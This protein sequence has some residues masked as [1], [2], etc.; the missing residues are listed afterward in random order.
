MVAT[1]DLSKNRDDSTHNKDKIE[2]IEHHIPPIKDGHY[3]ITLE[4]TVTG[5]GISEDN[6]FS[7]ATY[8]FSIL[9]PR[10]TLPPDDIHAVFPPAG[11]LGEHSN[12]FPHIVFNRS[13]LPWERNV[14][15]ETQAPWLALL[16]FDEQEAPKSSEQASDSPNKLSIITYKQL[17]ASVQDGI[18]VPSL[19][20]KNTNKKDLDHDDDK[21]TVIDVQW[22]TL[23]PILPSLEELKWLAHVR[24]TTVTDKKGKVIEEER[25]VIFGDRLPKAGIQSAVHLVSLENFYANQEDT[26]KNDDL[27]RLV[28]LK[29][30]RFAC[31]SHKHTFKKLLTGID[32]STLRL[33]THQ[34]TDIEAYYKLGAVPAPHA[35]RQGNQS[36][37]WY[38]GPLVPG[39]ITQ[40]TEI[41]LPVKAA[42]DL[43]QYNPDIGM[44]DVSYS[45]AWELGRLI[46]LQN[47]QFSI[48]LYNWKRTHAQQ[49]KCVE[50]SLIHAPAHLPLS[51]QA[52]ASDSIPVPPSISEWFNRLHLLQGIPFNYLVPDER[53]LPQ[54]SIRFFQIDPMW[55]ECLLDGAFSV[56]R[57]TTSDY[58]CDCKHREGD[59]NPTASR[60]S[61]I[62][63]IL[64]RS[65]VVSGWPGLL[66]DGYDQIIERNEFI[67][68]Q[69]TLEL[70]RMARLSPNVL[71]CLF[72]GEIKTIDIHQKPEMLHFGLDKQENTSFYKTLKDKYG[73]RLTDGNQLDVKVDNIPWQDQ[74][75]RIINVI[76]LQSDIHSKLG[77]KTGPFKSFTAAQFALEMIEGVE[78]VRFKKSATN[79]SQS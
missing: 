9:G 69:D 31:V 14:D 32:Q 11:S 25:A 22:Q 70:L 23:K 67:P 30:W 68:A 59:N 57:V 56:G 45:A 63:G 6:K 24:K 74:E 10:F 64:L 8:N 44:F 61:K 20:E 42:D 53:M 33:P 50:D 52:T 1:T 79:S 41:N 71:L 34:N 15:N 19:Q 35:M 48:N 77:G 46:A 29:S 75:N 66:V 47:K 58:N 37:S 18:K 28:S 12:T 21:I 2:F 40:Q 60:Y 55:M 73:N 4:Q 26:Y 5:T 17:K 76:Q 3:S 72:S 78:K 54:E 43:T 51:N 16:L 27:I 65:D 38:H 49:V 13:T 62:S 7:S 36:V 39:S